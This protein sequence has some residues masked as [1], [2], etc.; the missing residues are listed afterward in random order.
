MLLLRWRNKFGN[1]NQKMY[2]ENVKLETI[3]GM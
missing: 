3:I 2:S 1:I